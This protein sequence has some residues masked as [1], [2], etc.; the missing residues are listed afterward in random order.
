MTE[1]SF[2]LLTNGVVLKDNVLYYE[3]KETARLG[4][5]MIFDSD[6]Q[7]DIGSIKSE[8]VKEGEEHLVTVCV[9]DEFM[10]EAVYPVYID[11][12]VNRIDTETING[13]KTIQ[14]APVY[15]NNSNAAGGNA[16]NL[17]GYCGSSLGKS[18]VLYYLPGLI[19]RA[20]Y[21]SITASQINIVT[22]SLREAS[23]K[24][25]TAYVTS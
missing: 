15:S 1:Y 18:R 3:G 13:T 21:Q 4:D 5:I 7:A 14:D 8:T 16:Y 20:D 11:P 6:G 25:G 19:E 2:R 10:K 9:N 12:S 23:G 24:T 17:C 22:L